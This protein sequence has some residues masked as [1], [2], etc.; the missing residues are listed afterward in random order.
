MHFTVG[1]DGR[2]QR[3]LKDLPVDG[4]GDAFFQMGGQFRIT[5]SEFRE[6]VAERVT[7]DTA[8]HSRAGPVTLRSSGQSVLAHSCVWVH[9]GRI[10]TRAES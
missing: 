6:F 1:S 5:L 8:S 9:H 4:D 2:E 3:I 7:R 10:W